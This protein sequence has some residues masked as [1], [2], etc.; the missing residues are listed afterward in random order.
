MPKKQKFEWT[1]ELVMEFA[2]ANTEGSYRFNG[3][4]KISKK[5]EIFKNQKEHQPKGQICCMCDNK[6]DGYGNNAEPLKAGIC[7][8]CCNTEVIMARVM[9]T[10][11]TITDDYEKNKSNGKTN[12]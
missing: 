7:C 3:E 2:R 8:D 4:S 10:L 5:L 1:D 6:F 12:I 11:K 9:G